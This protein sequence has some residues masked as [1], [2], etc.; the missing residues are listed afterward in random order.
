MKPEPTL[1]SVTHDA[2]Q[3][4][5]E[6]RPAGVAAPAFL[7]YTVAGDC[8]VFDHTFVPDELR[9]QGLAAHLVRAALTEARSAGWK[10]FPACSYVATFIKRHSEF[11]DLINAPNQP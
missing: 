2:A 8:V 11:A 6:I 9:G 10:I 7:S 3:R 5:F 1:P 4:R